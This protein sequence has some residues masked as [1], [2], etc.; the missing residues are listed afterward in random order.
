VGRNW[1][2]FTRKKNIGNLESHWDCVGCERVT[3]GGARGAGGNAGLIII[4]QM[5]F[6][7]MAQNMTDENID[8]E[9]DMVTV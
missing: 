8:R 6:S 1:T 7:Q 4:L 2:W 3:K 9:N 5:F